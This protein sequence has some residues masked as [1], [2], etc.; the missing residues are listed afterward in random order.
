MSHNTESYVRDDSGRY[1]T[2]YTDEDFLAAVRDHMPAATSEVAEHVGCVR[3]NADRRLR[4]LRERGRVESKKIGASLVWFT[5][6]T[7]GE[8]T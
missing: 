6:D 2:R 5:A 1:S 8:T 3:Q 7:G 4:A